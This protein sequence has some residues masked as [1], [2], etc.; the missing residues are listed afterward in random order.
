MPILH[1]ATTEHPS[2]SPYPGFGIKGF[3]S[4]LA[5]D[6][7]ATLCV[8]DYSILQVSQRTRSMTVTELL[9]CFKSE[10]DGRQLNFLDVQ[11]RTCHHIL[12]SSHHPA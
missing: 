3:S 4:H 8:Y 7:E 1:R 5:R 12:P 6:N 9:E 11:N 2:L 10:D